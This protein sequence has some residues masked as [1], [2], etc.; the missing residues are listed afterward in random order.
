MLSDMYRLQKTS[1][2]VYETLIHFSRILKER[3][4][5]GFHRSE[6]SY[7]NSV[8]NAEYFGRFDTKPSFLEFS[9]TLLPS[10][11]TIWSIENVVD[12]IVPAEACK[13]HS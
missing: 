9:C 13:C 4:Y 11:R 2:Q 3:I 6:N 5:R 7:L 1:F 10:S 12:P 8:Y